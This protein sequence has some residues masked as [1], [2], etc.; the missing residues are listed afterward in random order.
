MHLL[1][2]DILFV[3]FTKGV[4]QIL[5]F[6]LIYQGIYFSVISKTITI[7]SKLPTPLAIMET[8]CSKMLK[9]KMTMYI[10]TYK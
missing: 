3:S 5:P 7:C 8:C 10:P 6:H 1:D 9:P 2:A 4:Q